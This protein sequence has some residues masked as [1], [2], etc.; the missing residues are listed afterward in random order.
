M[1]PGPREKMPPLLSRP[2]PP[3]PLF[4]RVDLWVLLAAT[5]AGGLAAVAFGPDRNWDLMNYHLYD[6]YAYLHG[7]YSFDVEPA[8]EA[9]SYVNPVADLP[10]YGM[11]QSINRWPR[12]IAFALGACH[13][14]NFFLLYRVI[15]LVVGD[16][17]RRRQALLRAAALAIGVSGAGAIG[18]LG[19]TTN[20]LI[21]SIFVLAALLPCL[22]LGGGTAEAGSARTGFLLAGACLGIAV[23]LKGTMAVFVP[24]FALIVVYLA[25]TTKKYA[26]L[27]LFGVASL[28]G[29]LLVAGHQMWI[30]WRLFD[31]P[32]FPRFNGIFRSPFYGPVNYRDARFLSASVWDVI[33]YPFYWA[34]HSGK[35]VQYLRMGHS[36]CFISSSF[37]GCDDF[38]DIRLALA[39]SLL[40]VLLAVGAVRLAIWRGR[41]ARAAAAAD[42]RFGLLIAFV[43]VSYLVWVASFAIYRY[44]VALEMLSGPVIVAAVIRLTPRGWVGT[45]I[46]LAAAIAA[47]GTTRYIEMA[48]GS[49]GTGYI[50]VSTWSP[51]A[52]S[53]LLIIGG[54]PV[55]FIVPY[56]DPS[57]RVLGIE[58]NYMHPDQDNRLIDRVRQALRERVPRF[59]LVSRGNNPTTVARTLATLHLI[60][61]IPCH[62][63][64]TNMYAKLQICP[65]SEF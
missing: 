31:N 12:V 4:R 34:F 17:D 37:P 33:F 44:A 32:V 10:F 55:A 38:R 13:G 21:A 5:V 50:E 24:A 61:T 8:A 26:G 57:V 65:L 22:R 64:V 2:M 25:V 11:V 3:I 45:A 28:A 56:L 35:P 40:V 52:G 1:R 59:L 27:L 20:D 30:L 49:F 43:V 51:P 60:T 6:P 14:V 23:G 18:V 29:L 58:N 9:M 39:E 54:A 47:I 42:I 19:T 16:G 63:V 62:D 41:R 46:A 7:R 53:Q 36:G 48:H 15:R